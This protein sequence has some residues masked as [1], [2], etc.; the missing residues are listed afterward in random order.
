MACEA[1]HR[2][3]E[4]CATGTASCQQCPPLETYLKLSSV[5]STY[6][7]SNMHGND[8]TQHTHCLTLIEY[9]RTLIYSTAATYIA[10]AQLPKVQQGSVYGIG[11]RGGYSYLAL[12]AANPT[13]NIIIFED[14]HNGNAHLA[15]NA[16]KQLFPIASL[17]LII[18]TSDQSVADV[19]ATQANATCSA[20]L[21]HS[22][23]DLLG[24]NAL[25]DVNWHI[26]IQ[27]Q[28]GSSTAIQQAWS[29]AVENKLI[30]KH[31][32][33]SAVLLP[34]AAQHTTWYNTLISDGVRPIG[35]RFQPSY[36][37]VYIGQYVHTT[38]D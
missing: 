11:I 2:L 23:T 4:C 25:A 18:G 22:E 10:A 37:D 3:W 33:M 7:C 19:L 27:D 17:Q 32:L 16:L 24:S 13:A 5:L 8:H 9:S 34:D 1:K 21:A 28:V 26:I 15:F 6:M 31:A 30:E 20:I 36:S 35:I 14:K 12:L 29:N 38:A